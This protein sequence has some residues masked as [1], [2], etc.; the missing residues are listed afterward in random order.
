MT[1]LDLRTAARMFY[2]STE[3]AA[4]QF[5]A[6]T[7]WRKPIAFPLATFDTL[8]IC[9]DPYFPQNRQ[10]ATGATDLS[11]PA[12][13]EVGQPVGRFGYQGERGAFNPALWTA[14]ADARPL[15]A[16]VEGRRCF[17]FD[18]IDDRL[19]TI[20]SINM[21]TPGLRLSTFGL[22]W[23][24]GATTG[25]PWTF[26]RGE[27][28]GS[29]VELFRCD[30]TADG[31]SATLRHNNTAAFLNGLAFGST[32]PAGWKLVYGEY[33]FDAFATNGGALRIEVNGVPV[34]SQAVSPAKSATTSIE[35]MSRIQ[36]GHRRTG[37]A[38]NMPFNGYL[39][40]FGFICRLL[41]T[42]EKAT[43]L[44]WLQGTAYVAP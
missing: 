4:L 19:D 1:T 37:G 13:T 2:G 6:E 44:Q 23:T 11:G 35:I 5:G 32:V 20:V 14:T 10:T 28:S 34:V 30:A 16:E 9:W 40:R 7:L 43:L 41:T 36:A 8:G 29:F 33:D 25:V 38:S 21:G 22:I 26:A 3:A 27:T 15:L 24:D 12:V 17:A 42:A 31:F 39:G 18:G